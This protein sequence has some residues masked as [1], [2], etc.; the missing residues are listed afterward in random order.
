MQAKED[1]AWVDSLGVK[2][3]KELRA[4]STDKILEAA[5]KKGAP[6]FAPDIDGRVLTE[7][8]P[9]T[10]A[11]GQAGACA[12]AGRLESRMKAAFLPSPA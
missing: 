6:E 2:S 10:Y 4:M 3:L 7:P 12:A 11:D 9:E 8:V 5:E 1:G